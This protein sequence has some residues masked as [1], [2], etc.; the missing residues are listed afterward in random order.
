MEA[1]LPSTPSWLEALAEDDA[2]VDRTLKFH[3]ILK[4]AEAG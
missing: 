4:Q 2:F 3:G 1:Y